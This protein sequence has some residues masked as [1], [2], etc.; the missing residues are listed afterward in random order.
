[1]ISMTWPQYC[2]RQCMVVADL[3]P[4]ENELLSTLLARHPEPL[5]AGEL[6]EVLWPDPEDEPCLPEN[7][8]GKLVASIRRK[9]GRGHIEH[10]GQG[11]RLCQQVNHQVGPSNA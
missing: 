1:M 3:S 10:D 2:R 6:V 7:R 9:I 11:Y 8:I 4:Q 5:A